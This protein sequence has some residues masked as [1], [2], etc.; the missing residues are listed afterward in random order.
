MKLIDARQGLWETTLELKN[1]TVKFRTRNSW[2]ENWGGNS[3]P[4]GKLLFYGE[5]IPVKA[6]RYRISLNLKDNTY[7]FDAIQQ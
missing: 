7:R 5:N 4:E 2:N 3:F 1:G 6:G